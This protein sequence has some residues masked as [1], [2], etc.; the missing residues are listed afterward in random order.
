MEAGRSRMFFKVILFLVKI[1]GGGDSKYLFSIY[2]LIPIALQDSAFLNLVYSTLF[3]GG[4][5]FITNIIRN[6]DKIIDAIKSKDMGS[7]RIIIGR[8]F[9][10][11]PIILISWIFFGWENYKLLF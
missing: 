4:I 8:K 6:F 2:L 9:S 1:M 11:S 7:L 10:F 5:I 3:L